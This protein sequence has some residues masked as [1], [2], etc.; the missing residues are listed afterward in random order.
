M[1]KRTR[2]KSGPSSEPVGLQQSDP[3]SPEQFQQTANSTAKERLIQARGACELSGTEAQLLEMMLRAEE[4]SEVKARSFWGDSIASL[5]GA[6]D[7]VEALDLDEA[8]AHLEHHDVAKAASAFYKASSE[9]QQKS[10]DYAK[11]WKQT[12]DRAAVGEE[13]SLGVRD[14]SGA[15]VSA[16]ASATGNVPLEVGTKLTL[17]ASDITNEWTRRG[18]R[19]DAFPAL[20][21]AE[22]VTSAIVEHLGLV[23]SDIGKALVDTGLATVRRITKNI[24]QYKDNPE[25][26]AVDVLLSVTEAIRKAA[27]TKISKGDKLAQ[28]VVDLAGKT[29]DAAT[30]LAID[31]AG[32]T[33]QSKS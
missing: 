3:V 16:Y 1:S 8:Y 4:Q 2:Q 18:L 31:H 7:D 9:H 19:P 26:L 22:R 14:I 29:A 33:P 20:M 23:E 27:A 32:G 12:E 10:D 24:D 30:E 6:P 28:D 21:A 11:G 5:L 17:A 15:V 13:V 25:K